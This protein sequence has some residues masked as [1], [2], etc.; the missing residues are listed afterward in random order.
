MLKYNIKGIYYSPNIPLRHRPSHFCPLAVGTVSHSFT[1][2]RILFMLLT[3]G[4]RW[5]WDQ[6]PKH[7]TRP[8]SNGSGGGGSQITGH[9]AN[10]ELQTAKLPAALPLQLQLQLHRRSIRNVGILRAHFIDKCW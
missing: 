1:L 7:K 9:C 3:G 2:P 8:L 4:K 5:S 6:K 10:C